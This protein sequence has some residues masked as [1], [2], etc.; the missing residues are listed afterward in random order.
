MVADELVLD[1]KDG[2]PYLFAWAKAHHIVLNE[3]HEILARK[4]GVVFYDG[5]TFTPLT[6]KGE[7]VN[8][9]AA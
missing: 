2:I 5:K 1:S 3:Y 8:R 7:D 6:K 9:G 4:H